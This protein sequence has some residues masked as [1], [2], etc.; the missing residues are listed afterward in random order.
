M[1][2]RCQ[3][4]AADAARRREVPTRRVHS[5]AGHDTMQ[6]AA[7]TDAG[8]LLVASENGHSH[9]PTELARWEDCTAATTVL[10]DA[11]LALVTDTDHD[12]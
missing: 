8:L 5:G 10:A 11:L 7:V 4:T 12:T 1:A 6:V 9:S 2:E 3:Q